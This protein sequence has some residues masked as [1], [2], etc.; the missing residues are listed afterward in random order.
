MRPSVIVFTFWDFS[1]E[2]R[3]IW[4]EYLCGQFWPIEWHDTQKVLTRPMFAC[5]PSIESSKMLL[6]NL[7]Q[8]CHEM[9][10]SSSSRFLPRFVLYIYRLQYCIDNGWL[11]II[12]NLNCHV[13]RWMRKISWESNQFQQSNHRDFHRSCAKKCKVIGAERPDRKCSGYNQKYSCTINYNKRS[14][15]LSLKFEFMTESE[16]CKVGKWYMV[17]G[18][19]DKTI[20]GMIG[21]I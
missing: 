13:R 20:R 12:H 16:W 8:F 1:R 5:W 14:H 18:T 15:I 7:G 9:D 10:Q 19:N 17:S 6:A 3:W 11:E 2:Y 21:L 4:E